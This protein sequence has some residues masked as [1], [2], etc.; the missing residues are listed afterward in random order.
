MNR[1]SN[2]QSAFRIGMKPE[3]WRTGHQ[4]DV[5]RFHFAV[6]AVIEGL[7]PDIG[8]H[9]IRDALIALATERGS[10][11][12]QSKT[13]VALWAERASYIIAYVRDQY[14]HPG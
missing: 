5:K 3:T 4:L 14:D 2:L 11:D 8:E 9:E 1:Q 10:V 12:A 13:E 7:G 6:R